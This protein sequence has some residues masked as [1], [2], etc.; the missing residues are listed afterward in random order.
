[1]GMILNPYTVAAAATSIDGTLGTVDSGILAAVLFTVSGTTVTVVG[2]KNVASV[3]RLTGA[4]YRI[5]FTSALAH[6]NY[7]LM[8]GA[9]HAGTNNNLSMLA[10][11]NRD[12]TTGNSYS[13]AQV[14]VATVQAGGI[15]SDPSHCAI[16]IYDPQTISASNYLAA[17]SWTV[18]GTTV[19]LQRQTNVSSMSRHA[20]GV[21]RVN[22]NSALADANYAEWCM[23]RY[24]DF[25]NFAMPLAGTNRNTGIPSNLHTTAS[26]DLATG[27]LNTNG[28]SFEAARGSVLVGNADV[29]P[30][31]TIARARF[32]VSGSAC[33][34]IDSYNVSSVTYT[35]TGIYR[36]NFTLPCVDAAYGVIGNGKWPNASGDDT[37]CI[38]ALNNSVSGNNKYATDGVDISATSYAAGNFDPSEV[39]VWVL[40]PW[41]M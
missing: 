10:Q 6:T 35:A 37:P 3:T 29:A 2:Q 15:G 7:G 41:L 23:S 34:L 13:T 25:S 21:Y 28:A 20:A 1:M 32:S 40:K 24:A 9:R 8:G 17:A 30:R 5:A 19:T 33:T 22:F 14:D 18:S 39:N 11:P 4:I 38:G 12:S 16:V 31:G 36:V 27:I 26:L